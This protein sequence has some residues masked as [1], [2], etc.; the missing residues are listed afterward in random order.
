MD[1]KKKKSHVGFSLNL[2]KEGDMAVY[3]VLESIPSYDR[4]TSYI[5]RAVIFYNRNC[6]DSNNVPFETK[7]KIPVP[8]H[9]NIEDTKQPKRKKPQKTAEMGNEKRQP[10]PVMSSQE[11][12]TQQQAEDILTMSNNS[13]INENISYSDI[14]DTF[15]S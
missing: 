3:K 4:K 12:Q 15:F 11:L 7:Q 5:K 14:V 2:E 6:N 9:Q 1:E 13:D 8:E 10:K